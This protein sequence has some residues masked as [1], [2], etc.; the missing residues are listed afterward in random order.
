VGDTGRGIAERHLPQLCQPCNRR[1][2]EADG[3][4]GSG[5]GLSLCRRLT[6]LMRGE[7]GVS[8]VEGEGSTFWLD[9]SRVHTAG[10]D[11]DTS[12]GR[13]ANAGAE[14]P[15]PVTTAALA[16]AAG[17]RVAGATVLYIEDNPANQELMTQIVSRHDGLTLLL[18]PNGRLGLEL[19]SAHAPDLIL[20]DIHLPDMDGYELLRRLRATTST[21]RTP[22]IAVS[23]DAMPD[24]V[25]RSRAAG[26]DDQVAKPIQVQVLDQLLAARLPQVGGTAPGQS[27]GNVTLA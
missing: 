4:E 24:E 11:G 15:P 27:S 18:A 3:I 26:F 25:A 12:T 16:A 1:G 19:A 13:A 20:L 17:A 21:R 22:V 7:M 6:S 14:H 2:G 10:P 9:L 23:A 8:S 5:I